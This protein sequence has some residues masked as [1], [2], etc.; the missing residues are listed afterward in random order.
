MTDDH[1]NEPKYYSHA[2]LFPSISYWINRTTADDR[3]GIPHYEREG[4]DATST[5]RS[6]N[7]STQRAVRSPGFWVA[8]IVV[9]GAVIFMMKG[10]RR[11]A[12]IF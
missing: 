1:W 9:T 11:A 4:G 10:G 5:F 2:G 12:M 8:A 7:T 3:V 6:W